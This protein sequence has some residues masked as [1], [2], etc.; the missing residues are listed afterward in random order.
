MREKREALE[1]AC[2]SMTEF[3]GRGNESW[4][5]AQSIH[6]FIIKI[7]LFFIILFIKRI[8]IVNYLWI[9]RLLNEFSRYT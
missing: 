6:Y 4:S 3:G 2:R 8:N 1:L 5:A 7:V 9:N